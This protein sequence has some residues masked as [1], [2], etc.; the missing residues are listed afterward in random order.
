MIRTKKQQTVMEKKI[1][2]MQFNAICAAV[3][4]TVLYQSEYKLG[5]IHA[6]GFMKAPFETE[7][8]VVKADFDYKK[9]RMDFTFY[10]ACFGWNLDESVYGVII[11]RVN[12]VVPDL[13][14]DYLGCSCVGLGE[15]Y[16]LSFYPQKRGRAD[17]NKGGKERSQ[18]PPKGKPP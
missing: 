3:F 17:A 9:Q 8:M 2:F 13:A 1:D 12:N 10:N 16:T 18:Q 14:F 4:G 6:V 7:R 11:E 15:D 5:E